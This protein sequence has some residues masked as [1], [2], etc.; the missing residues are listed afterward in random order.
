MPAELLQR[1]KSVVDYAC[2]ILNSAHVHTCFLQN[3]QNKHNSCDEKV[4]ASILK[5]T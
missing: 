4:G 2:T 1:F 5:E 3:K